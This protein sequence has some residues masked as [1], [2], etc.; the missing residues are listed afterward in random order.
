M[1]HQ[2]DDPDT[3]IIGGWVCEACDKFVH[4]SEVDYSDELRE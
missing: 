2:D 4:D 3:G 1:W